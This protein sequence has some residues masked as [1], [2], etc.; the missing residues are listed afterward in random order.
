MAIKLSGWQRLW[1]VVA[2]VYLMAV[3]VVTWSTRPTSAS[4]SHEFTLYLHLPPEAR[5]RILN[6]HVKAENEQEFIHDA[7]TAKDAELVEM[8]NSHMLV[9]RKGQPRAEAEA[10]A[11]AYWAAIE[12][13]ANGK[14][15][16][17]FAQ[18]IAWWAIPLAL[19]YA[20]GLAVRWTYRG[21]KQS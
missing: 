21:F 10:S 9:F 1:I 20:F 18:A 17:H 13:V 12:H 8:P 6:S 15:I 3:A 19:L 2:V 4:V 7:R 14:L 5:T 16:A 11:R